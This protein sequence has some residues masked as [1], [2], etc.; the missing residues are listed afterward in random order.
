MIVLTLLLW[1]YVMGTMKFKFNGIP[2]NPLFEPEQQGWT[3]MKEP[4]PWVL[5]AF[6]LPV[7]IIAA[8][9]IGALWWA[10]VDIDF[11]AVQDLPLPLAFILICVLMIVI[12]EIV[13]ML[14]HPG[15]GMSSDTIMGFWPAKM[16]FFAHWDA[17]LTRKRFLTILVMPFVVLSV[18]PLLVGIALG[19]AHP[20]VAAFTLMNALA[21]CCDLLGVALVLAGVPRNAK[22][23][24]KGWKTYYRVAAEQG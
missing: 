11:K 18:L 20:Y 2:E 5:Q 8:G 1:V 4:S 21:A 22:V 3:A 7:G 24:N 9:C 17:E 6:G 13:H 12:H 23:R 16:L 19:S 15:A 10:F 14:A